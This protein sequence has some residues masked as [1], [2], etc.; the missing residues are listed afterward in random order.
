MESSYEITSPGDTSKQ[1][2]RKFPD[3][4]FT[5]IYLNENV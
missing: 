4:I 5:C 1:N 3:D 2:G